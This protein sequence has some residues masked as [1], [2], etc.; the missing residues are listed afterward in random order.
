VIHRY[1]EDLI[2]ELYAKRLGTRALFCGAADPGTALSSSRDLALPYQISNHASEDE[3]AI[4]DVVVGQILG[5]HR[6]R[7]EGLSPDSPSPACVITRVVG[8]FQIHRPEA[9]G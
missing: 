7:M 1:E 8:D 4:L 3:L 5:F 6:C 2:R 9:G